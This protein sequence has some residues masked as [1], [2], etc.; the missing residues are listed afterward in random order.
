MSQ[1]L[2]IDPRVLVDLVA[3]NDGV[4]RWFDKFSAI[5]AVCSATTLVGAMT[6]STLEVVE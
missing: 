3:V 6:T 1:S 5:L 4:P 2:G